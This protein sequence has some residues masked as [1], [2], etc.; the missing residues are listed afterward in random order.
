VTGDPRDD[1]TYRVLLDDYDHQLI[2][3]GDIETTLEV[4]SDTARKFASRL[5]EKG[6][7]DRR[8]PSP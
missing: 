8:R 2:S 7:F 1:T 3:I 4:S 6:W 5:T